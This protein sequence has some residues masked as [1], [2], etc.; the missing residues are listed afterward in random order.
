MDNSS[1]SNPSLTLTN[2]LEWTATVCFTKK[3]IIARAVYY[4]EILSSKATSIDL[5]TSNLMI[6]AVTINSNNNNNADAAATTNLHYS[7]WQSLI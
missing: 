5:D 6:R 1:Q 2:H 7:L 3:I 4:V